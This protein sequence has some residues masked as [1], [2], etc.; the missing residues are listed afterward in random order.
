MKKEPNINKEKL[1]KFIEANYSLK[2]NSF[3]FIPR[4][5]D[6]DSYTITSDKNKK[7]FVKIYD[8]QKIKKLKL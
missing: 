8:I 3:K 5:F 2:V 1:K 6:A 7:Y 4:G